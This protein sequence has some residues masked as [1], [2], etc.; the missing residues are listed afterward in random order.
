MLWKTAISCTS[1]SN[2]KPG[3]IDFCAAV[4]LTLLISKTLQ[5]GQSAYH[6]AVR[7]YLPARWSRPQSQLLS[8]AG[9]SFEAT[10]SSFYLPIILRWSFDD[11]SIIL[12]L[13]TKDGRRMDEGWGFQLRQ[14]LP[15]ARMLTASMNSQKELVHLLPADAG[16]EQFPGLN[17]MINKSPR[18]KTTSCSSIFSIGFKISVPH[19]KSKSGWYG[20]RDRHIFGRK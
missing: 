20:K 18:C 17:W 14:R 15:T 11:P 3:T 6:A 2:R 9:T 12:R 5:K 1:N 7:K 16:Q 4:F 13:L 8:C 19:P 10:H